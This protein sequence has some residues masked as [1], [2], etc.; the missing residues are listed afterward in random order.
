MTNLTC[1]SVLR[2][3]TFVSAVQMKFLLAASSKSSTGSSGT[4]TARCAASR[5]HR[6]SGSWNGLDVTR[7]HPSWFERYSFHRAKQIKISYLY[8]GGRGFRV[9]N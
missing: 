2:D 9:V 3:D 7:V 4:L 5:C 8:I 1:Y 6:H